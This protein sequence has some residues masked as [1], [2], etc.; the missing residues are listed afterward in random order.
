MASGAS[1]GVASPAMPQRRTLLL[2]VCFFLSGVGSLALEVVWTRELRLVFGS[3]TL[4]ASTILVAYM[5]GLG[6]GGLAGGKLAARMPSGVRAYGWIEIV[7]G[8]YALAVPWLLAQLPALNRTVLAGMDFWPAVFCRFAISL[9]LLLLPTVLMGA[10]LPI[11]VAA[12]VRRDARIGS[13]TGLLY[14]LNTLGAVAGVFLATFVLFELFG[15]TWT[16][17]IGALL[18]VV[19]GILSLTVVDRV[20]RAAPEPETAASRPVARASAAAASSETPSA[21]ASRTGLLLAVYAAVGFTALLYEVAW[22]RALAVVFGSS[23]YAFASMLGAF[24]TGIALGSLLFRRWIDATRAPLALLAWGIVTLAVLGLG[25]TLVLPHLPEAFLWMV[26]RYGLDSG[27]IAVG[28]VLMCIVAMLPPTLVLGGLFPLVARVLG[29]VLHEPGEAVGRVYFANTLGSAAGAFCTGFFLL[30]WLGIR[31]TLALGAGIDLLAAALL[32]FAATRARVLALVPLAATALLLV[33]PIPFDRQA[34]TR[35]VF[36]APEAELTFGIATD[37]IDGRPDG[38]L[39]FYRDGI[40]ATVSVQ[41]EGGILALRVNGKTDASSYGDMS[42]QVLLGQLPLLFGPPAKKVLVIGYASGVTTGSVA[43]HDSVERIDAVEIE[44][45][46]IE[47]SHWFD[48]VNGKPLEDPRVHLVLDDARSYLA[49][50]RERYDVII[51]EPSNPWMSGV[52]NLFTSEFFK[53]V[54]GALAPGG[55]LLQW[56]QLYALDPPSLAS[57]V[58]ALHGEFPYVYGFADISGSPDLLLLAQDH[59]LTASDLPRWEKLPEKVRADVE[60]IGNFS[61]LDL[62]S[63][64][65]VT[66]ADVEALVRRAPKVN[67][68][69]NLFIELGT[70]WML[71]D[72]TNRANWDAMASTKGSLVPLFQQ[73]GEPLDGDRMGAFAFSH[74]RKDS[75]ATEELL[76]TAN[77]HAR[78]G[79]AIAAATV[80]ARRVSQGEFPLEN[81]LAAADEAVSLAPGAFEPLLLRA[82][83]RDESRDFAGA[84]ADAEAAL[85]IRPGDL[86]ARALRMRAL[87]QQQRYPEAQQDADVLLATTF[88][89]ADPRVL[90][91]APEV[92]L[93]NGQTKRAIDLLEFLLRERDPTW[94]HGWMLLAYAYG[95]LGDEKNALRAQENERLSRRNRAEVY[96]RMARSALW[97]GKPDDAADLLNAALQ[98]DP[99]YEAARVE[100]VRLVPEAAEG[101]DQADTADGAAAPAR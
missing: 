93:R 75:G 84:L 37:W 11:L 69:D 44:P 38:E 8:L 80:V 39:M 63:L 50:T 54:K 97:V 68:D 77:T 96:H 24:L 51:S 22:S 17:R 59:P 72:E 20:F 56:V 78:S 81:Q 31:D 36:K 4:A 55:R 34:L 1:A 58:A 13:S 47:A 88:G 32:L 46:I 25:T 83:I 60:R 40:N 42:T 66:P 21:L 90:R 2:A 94:T 95:Q 29:D 53:I 10:T 62:W 18:D 86:R 89:Q 61:S 19:V 92:T 28:R 48:D 49:A 65:R 52:S 41:R 15:L 9:A 87:A 71:Y 23:I 12:L 6:L 73:L 3:T 99:D 33:V 98:T 26:E 76:R 14:G 57:I 16:N 64:L 82:E 85:A 45:A 7:I 101:S 30:P 70:P 27:R 100:L 74:A 5:L 91:E 67:T 43:T 79:T 35:G